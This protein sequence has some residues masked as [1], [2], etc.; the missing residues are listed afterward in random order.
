MDPHRAHL[1]QQTLLY[2]QS[3]GI[4]LSELILYALQQY[5]DPSHPILRDL[6]VHTTSIAAALYHQEATTNQL[7]SW[8][9]QL[10]CIRYGNAMHKLTL[11]EN[12]WHFNAAQ[13]HPDQLRDFR[14]ED[15]VV[16]MYRRAGELWG[17]FQAMMGFKPGDLPPVEAETVL[18]E[19]DLDAEYWGATTTELEEKK[20]KQAKFVNIKIAVILSI[21]AQGRDP[22]CNA[23]QSI[24]G[25]FCHACNAPEKLVKV[26]S[27]MGV[28]VSLKSVHRA[29]ISLSHKSS[30]SIEELGAT[31]LASIGFD[32]F[33][34]LLK[35]LV[36]TVDDPR[37]RG[38]LHMA[39]GT[40]LRLDHGVTLEDLRCSRLIWARSEFNTLSP[41]R[42]LF[43]PTATLEHLLF[44]HPETN[45]EG[46][47]SRRGQFRSWMFQRTLV[48]HG[49][50]FFE[51]YAAELSEPSPVDQ[52][53][54]TTLYQV[55][56]RAMD[57]N[58][59]TVSGNIE[60]IE[61]MFRQAGIGDPSIPGQ[62]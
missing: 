11:R 55:P 49:P 14:I 44:L 48:K 4:L 32:N 28:S 15:M 23:L 31:L 37:A 8:A 12:G 40:L 34:Q 18:D 61:N 10:A 57:I 33:D 45:A 6:V 26:L 5:H 50:E 25:I 59:S 30:E 20:A 58:L 22:R 42:C 53:P 38:M 52:I 17:L 9:H 51:K 21:L 27:K 47:L 16:G 29:I 46:S 1:I 60:A 2:L 3:S 19:D 24:V 41:D 54:V 36:A 56:L 35:A 39:S 43:D 13:T 7:C 62:S